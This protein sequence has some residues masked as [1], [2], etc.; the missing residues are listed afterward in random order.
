MEDRDILGALVKRDDDSNYSYTSLFQYLDNRYAGDTERQNYAHV[1]ESMKHD[2]K[3]KALV[4]K[5]NK[6]LRKI[7]LIKYGSEDNFPFHWVEYMTNDQQWLWEELKA[8]LNEQIQRIF[9]ESPYSDEL[10]LECIVNLRE[11]KNTER[12]C[13]YIASKSSGEVNSRLNA[14]DSCK[15][16]V[17]DA[18]EHMSEF[19][20]DTNGYR[21]YKPHY[22]NDIK[23]LIKNGYH[24]GYN[25]SYFE[26]KAKISYFPNTKSLV[27]YIITCIAIASIFYI[28]MEN[29]LIGF[30]LIICVLA[31]IKMI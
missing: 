9:D 24:K 14:I 3:V 2:Q 15:K 8:Y 17:L 4:G 19:N 31:L 22:I 27:L 13:S 30:F 29:L 28:L 18:P 23:Y 12:I 10:A 7:M 5:Y 20:I 21:E 6:L 26:I 1:L 11:G 25:D 16:T